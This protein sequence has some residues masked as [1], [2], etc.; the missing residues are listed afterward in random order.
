MMH[1]R[2]R[3]P[4]AQMVRAGIE[5]Q[6]APGE[7]G[8]IDQFLMALLGGLGAAQ[9][10]DTYQVVGLETAA[11]VLGQWAGG[12]VTV[13][14]RP[15]PPVDLLERMK[16]ALGP[17]RRPAGKVLRSATD[18]FGGSTQND[19][20]AVGDSD[21]FFENL[22]L[23][24]LHIPYVAHYEKTRIPTVLTLHDL[25]HRH[26]P[27]FFAADQLAWRERAYPAAIEHARV[28]VTDCE[29][30]RAD[31]IRQYGADP[32]KVK[33]VLLASPIR[34][35]R[36][37]T[38]EVGHALRTTLGLPADFALYPALTYGHKNHI[39]LL[40][41]VAALR[42]QHGVVVSVVCPGRQKLH[43]PVIRKRLE[44]LRLNRQVI[45][46]GFVPADTLRLLYRMARLVVFPSLFEGAGLP[47]LEALSEGTPLACSD[48]PAV[49][50]Y[51]GTAALF[52]DPTS[53]DEIAA[54]IAEVWQ[55]DELRLDL[56][57]RGVLRSLQFSPERMADDYADLYRLAAA[58]GEDRVALV[59]AEATN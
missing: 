13:V 38:A 25:Q 59:G 52:F 54:T 49:R 56:A 9:R 31:I 17:I 57:E 32:A 22:G 28:V 39:R 48:I 21:G 7:E 26:F 53:V 41:A 29:W 4:A 24:V 15:T 3:R 37:P 55:D 2:I 19:P 5:A 20:P 30:G 45:F 43:W 16:R 51:A 36:E 6:I 40:E 33:V 50:E 23:D 11:D 42:D 1:G 12:C 18:V 27:E 8:G 34:S 10:P 44:E 35:Y 47:V 46:P 14:A 58:P